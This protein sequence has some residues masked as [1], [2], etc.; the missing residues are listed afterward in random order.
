ML[1]EVLAGS[2]IKQLGECDDYCIH[3]ID[4]S[5]VTL[6]GS[7]SDCIGLFHAAAYKI[8]AE[9]LDQLETTDDGGLSDEASIYM[10][11]KYQEKTAGVIRISGRKETVRLVAPVVRKSVELMIECEFGKTASCFR[12][13]AKEQLLNYFLYLEPDS[14]NLPR[15]YELMESMGYHRNLPRIPV[16]L[17]SESA[18]PQQ[19]FDTVKKRFPMSSQDIAAIDDKGNFILFLSYSESLDGFFENY[20]FYVEDFLKEFLLRCHAHNMP[21]YIYTGPMLI[22]PDNYK[23][24]YEITLWL[25][26]TFHAPQACIYFYEHIDEYFKSKLPLIELHKIFEV[27]SMNYPSEF[28]EQLLNHMEALHENNYNFQQSSRQLFI[29][30][31]TF[32]FRLSKIRERLGADPIQNL[33]DRELIE[34][35]CYYLHHRSLY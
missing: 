29:H 25:K 13:G 1:N 19:I 32:S 35:L 21:V 8:I 2:F 26:E 14:A 17:S 15:L 20:R 27:F 30:K 22:S 33:R 9:Q 34:Y 23:Y 10:P 28:S 3:I 31:N 12:K 6:A 18:L 4:L 7:K 11:L 5:G 16:L 24:G